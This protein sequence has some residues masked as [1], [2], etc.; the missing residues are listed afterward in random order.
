MRGSSARWLIRGR[1]VRHYLVT[2]A[3]ARSAANPWLHIVGTTCSG[4]PSVFVGEATDARRQ[5]YRERSCGVD[6]WQPGPSCS[7]P[8]ASDAHPDTLTGPTRNHFVKASREKALI[9]LPLGI[10]PAVL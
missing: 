4:S 8:S 9:D 10:N 5:A 3:C 2:L 7:C 1:R 6:P